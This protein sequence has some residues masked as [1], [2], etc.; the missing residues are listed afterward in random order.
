[1]KTVTPA[2][3]QA[4]ADELGVPV[5]AVR[6]VAEVEVQGDATLPTGEPKILFERHYFRKFTGGKFNATH[7]DLSGPYKKGSYGAPSKQHARLAAAVKLNRDAALMSASWGM[8][9]IMGANFKRAGYPTVQAFI[10]EMYGGEA[11]QLRAFVNYIKNSKPLLAALRA[12]NWAKF[13]ELY[14][15]PSYRDNNYDKKMQGAYTKWANGG[16][17]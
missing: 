2:Q 7:P 6:A 13:A 4:A 12:L 1:M 5:A 9:Q 3:W 14:N 15:G 17:G 11:G 16:N 10:N 8:F